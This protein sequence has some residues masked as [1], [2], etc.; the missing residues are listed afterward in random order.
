MI[1]DRYRSALSAPPPKGGRN[2]HLLGAASLAVYAGRT[3]AEDVDEIGEAWG[4]NP[5]E[6]AAEVGHAY[7]KALAL[8]KRPFSQDGHPGQPVPGFRLAP[9]HRDPPPLGAGAASY[10]ARVPP[11]QRQGFVMPKMATATANHVNE[12][13]RR[14]FAAARAAVSA[15]PTV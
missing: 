11:E 9:V 6:A 7:E 14:I 8:G 3:K 1:T 10:V 5:T 13:V 15:L 4:Y 12:I 2:A